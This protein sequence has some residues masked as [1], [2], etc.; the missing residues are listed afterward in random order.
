MVTMLKL[1]LIDF[2]ECILILKP[3]NFSFFHENINE[4]MKNEIIFG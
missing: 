1:E 3:C 4:S 2:W